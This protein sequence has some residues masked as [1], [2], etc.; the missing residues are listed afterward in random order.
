M[1]KTLKRDNGGATARRVPL[2]LSASMLEEEEKTTRA[3]IFSLWRMLQLFNGY[4]LIL[5]LALASLPFYSQ[6]FPFFPEDRVWVIAIGFLLAALTGI[7][8]LLSCIWRKRFYEQLTA[9]VFFDAFFIGFLS[10]FLNDVHNSHNLALLISIAGASLIAQGRMAQLYAAMATISV[11][12]TE[13]LSVIERGHIDSEITS[14]GFLSV[15]FFAL[16]TSATLLGRYMARNEAL[17]RQHRM[18]RD[19]QMRISQ[20]VMEQMQD[21]V[22]IVDSEGQIIGMNIRA[23]EILDLTDTKEISLSSVLPELEAGY[24]RWRKEKGANTLEIIRAASDVS[25]HAKE[26]FARFLPTQSTTEQTLI[27]LEDLGRLRNEAQQLKLASLGRLTANIAHEIRNPLAAISHASE[28]LAE[29]NQSPLHDRLS[30]IIHDNIHRLDRIIQDILVLGRQSTHAETRESICLKAWLERF[31]ALLSEQEK[32]ED[33]V[34][35]VRAPKDAY[36]LF[37]P[38]QLQQVMWNLVMNALRYSTRRQGAI[39]LEAR[40]PDNHVELHV[41]DDG[42]GISQ[43]LK[44]QVFEPFFTTFAQGT[45]LGLH[46]AQELCLAN[47]SRL[48]LGNEG[49]GHFILRGVIPA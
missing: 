45:G 24:R 8:L 12:V 44:A 47:Q 23:Q 10:Y 33:G 36:L 29:D 28:L 39:R 22:L 20:Q 27:F 30:K 19:N 1:S 48:F 5:N 40:L 41:I 31:A 21:G 25:P 7:G 9:Q 13:I 37:A 2:R 46:I 43:E 15:G 18:E 17:A 38:S 4:R 14:A 3:G 6:I 16:A 42:P 35:M 49:G 32:L 11:L 34:L 26:I